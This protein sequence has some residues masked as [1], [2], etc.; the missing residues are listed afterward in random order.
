MVYYVCVFVTQTVIVNKH[1]SHA[2]NPFPG[3]YVTFFFFILLLP[4]KTFILFNVHTSP[5]AFFVSARRVYNSNA[6][7]IT[8]LSDLLYS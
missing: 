6:Y 1:L 5:H 8:K 3:I 4:F 2:N 7:N